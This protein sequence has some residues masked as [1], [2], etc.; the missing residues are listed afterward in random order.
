MRASTRPSL[1]AKGRVA[2]E[3]STLSRNERLNCGWVDQG[4]NDLDETV[5]AGR[6][7]SNVMASGSI[8]PSGLTLEPNGPRGGSDCGID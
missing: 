4:R 3:R 7:E 2:Q 6:E 5:V 1:V 8:G